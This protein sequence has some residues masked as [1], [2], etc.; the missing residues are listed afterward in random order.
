MTSTRRRAVCSRALVAVLAS[1]IL[2][3]TRASASHALALRATPG[4]RF[5]QFDHPQAGSTTGPTTIA[6]NGD[7]AGFYTDA[8]DRDHGFVRDAATGAFTDVDAPGAT[9][10]WVL[11]LNAHGDVSGTF[12]DATGAQH[13]F[14][15]DA[16]GFHT[17]DV[18]GAVSTSPATSEFG[19]GLGT[20]VG[21]I[22]DDGAVTGA[23]GT[24]A[25]ASHGFVLRSG[26]HRADLD[27]PG[28]STAMD[29]IFQSEG[30]TGAIRSNARGDVVGYFAPA[31]RSSLSPVDVRAYR[32]RAGVWKTLLPPGSFT[33][34]QWPVRTADGRHARRP[35]RGNGPPASPF[36][37][38]KGT[39]GIGTLA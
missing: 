33:S 20:A 2:T 39:L 27:A 6:E 10:T 37:G 8:A 19:T 38:A 1:A 14:L 18:P 11:G 7:V 24:A 9:D 32:L 13:G 3:A 25:G 4:Y 15:R 5:L 12:K 34:H 35:V 16:R 36:R 28:A 31:T 22:G 23:W 26:H 17:I 30:G 29:P 21:T